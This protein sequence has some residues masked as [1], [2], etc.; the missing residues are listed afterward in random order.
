MT[1]DK[2]YAVFM[3][4]AGEITT[5]VDDLNTVRYGYA[6]PFYWIEMPDGKRDHR[7]T[8]GELVASLAVLRMNYPGI[9][10]Q[11]VGTLPAPKRKSK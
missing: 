9:K 10:L 2:E 7:I 3:Y 4:E 5:L 8:R 11:L 6:A 1:S